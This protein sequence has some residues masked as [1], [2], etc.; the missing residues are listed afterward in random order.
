MIHATYLNTLSGRNSI[1]IANLDRRR[2]H[3]LPSA[4]REAGALASQLPHGVSKDLGGVHRFQFDE[5]TIGT[6]LFFEIAERGYASLFK[7]EDFV[8]GLIHIAQQV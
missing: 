3:Q 6:T 4:C 1:Q 8:A 2:H 7:N 5:P